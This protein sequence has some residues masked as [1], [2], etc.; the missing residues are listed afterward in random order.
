[1]T[2]LCE[3]KTGLFPSPKD[4]LFTCSCPDWASMCKH[5]AAVLYGDRRATGSSA[6]AALHAPQGRSTGLD[7]E[8]LG[9]ISRRR[10]GDQPARR[11]SR[12]T[13]CRRC[14]A[15]R[16]RRRR[17]RSGL[18]PVAVPKRPPSSGVT[19]DGSTTKQQVLPPP[20]KLEEDCACKKGRRWRAAADTE[21]ATSDRGAHAH[22][23]GRTKSRREEAEG[24]RVAVID[25]R[26]EA[27]RGS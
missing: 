1:M 24:F 12:T 23:L 15:S 14:S 4:I 2:R 6:G 19:V 17:R 7:C 25:P 21:E 5:V 16:W 20:A 11:F 22:V 26:S 18:P 27:T 13:I 3:E 8:R 9:P 10:A